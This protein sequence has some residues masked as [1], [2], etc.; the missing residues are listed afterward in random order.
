MQDTGRW[1]EVEADK[2]VSGEE[3]VVVRKVKMIYNVRTRSSSCFCSACQDSQYKDCH[4][5]RAYPGL[6]SAMR[7]GEVKET[8]IMDTG[9]APVDGGPLTE[10]TFGPRKKLCEMAR[11]TGTQWHQSDST[12]AFKLWEELGTVEQPTLI[13]RFGRW[14]GF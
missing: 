9:T 11:V 14:A 12:A 10:I 13:S 8:V 3:M 7:N 6:V 2:P 4:V 1:K 5:H